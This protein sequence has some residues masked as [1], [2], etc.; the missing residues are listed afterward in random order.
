MSEPEAQASG[1]TEDD[2][3]RWREFTAARIALGRA[4]NALPTAENLRFGWA[5]AMARDA[6][7][8]P[9]DV[10]TLTAKLTE[11]GWPVHCVRS[12][13]GD[14]MTYLRRPDLGRR[15][16]ADDLAALAAVAN[17]PVDGP[18]DISLTIGDGLSSLAV[19]RHALPLLQALQR[20][21]GDSFRLAPLVV[22][23]QA[24]VALADE[25]AQT[26]GARLGIILIGERPGLSSPDSLGIYLTHDPRVGRHDAERNCISNVRPEG[27]GY[28]AAAFRLAW[29]V[30]QALRLGLSGVE[31]KDES[32]TAALASIDDRST[33][34]HPPQTE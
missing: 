10:T 20:E 30:R 4:G 13:A 6:I 26:F 17:R 16:A 28:A 15:L 22:A 2:W 8:T 11:A 24:R 34:N 18:M 1:I 5:H 12:Q 3:G 31:L 7:H 9:L 23:E 27:L 33:L 32:E 19:Q 25:I 14:R 29:L 21:L